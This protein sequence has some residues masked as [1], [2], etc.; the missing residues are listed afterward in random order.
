[1]GVQG[2]GGEPIGKSPQVRPRRRRENNI[3]MGLQEFGWG[4]T[5]WVELVLDREM[6]RELVNGVMILRVP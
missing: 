4:G 1:M 5:S 3:K 2:F 6:W